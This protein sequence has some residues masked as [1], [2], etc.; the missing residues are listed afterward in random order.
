[1][2]EVQADVHP[3]AYGGSHEGPLG[4]PRKSH[5]GELAAKGNKKNTTLNVVDREHHV[6]PTV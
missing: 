1:M 5:D 6:A 2:D 4:S 3:H